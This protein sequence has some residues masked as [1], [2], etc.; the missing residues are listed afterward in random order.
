[1]YRNMVF[2]SNIASLTM[3]LCLLIESDLNFF[4]PLNV[5][6]MHQVPMVTEKYGIERVKCLGLSVT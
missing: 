4:Y 3:L 6:D 5:A 2:L 1:M